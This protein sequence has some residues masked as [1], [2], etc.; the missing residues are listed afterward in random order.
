M[1]C[2]QLFGKGM[3]R[4]KEGGVPVGAFLYGDLS[5]L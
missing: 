5:V 1:V 3:E 4:W 2:G